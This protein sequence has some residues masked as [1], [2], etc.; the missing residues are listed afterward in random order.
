MTSEEKLRQ[1]LLAIA[2]WLEHQA[3]IL[4]TLKSWTARVAA[5]RRL[6]DKAKV[7]RLFVSDASPIAA[8][9]APCMGDKGGGT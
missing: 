1:E 4:P 8:H 9:N 5:S 2:T 3:S 7:L 6:C